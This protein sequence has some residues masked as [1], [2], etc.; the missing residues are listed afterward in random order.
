MKRLDRELLVK[1][2]AELVNEYNEYAAGG[3]SEV[4]KVYIDPDNSVMIAFYDE[5]KVFTLLS[6]ISYFS[7]EVDTFYAENGE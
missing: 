5:V 1:V 2:L 4:S 3:N 6:A 7:D